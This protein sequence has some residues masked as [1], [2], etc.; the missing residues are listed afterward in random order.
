MCESINKHIKTVLLIGEATERFEENLK[1][2][3]FD[4][5]LYVK[6]QTNAIKERIKTFNVSSKELET[7]NLDF[8]D[9]DITKYKKN[10]ARFKTNLA[11]D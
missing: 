8:N 7:T 1:K 3:G 4:N 10:I 9:I 2:N 6:L 5:E 11:I